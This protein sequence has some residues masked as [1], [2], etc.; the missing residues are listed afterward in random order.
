MSVNIFETFYTLT[1]YEHFGNTGGEIKPKVPRFVLP[2]AI[3][4]IVFEPKQKVQIFL[5]L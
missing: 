4:K 3:L 2:K 5:I 1:L